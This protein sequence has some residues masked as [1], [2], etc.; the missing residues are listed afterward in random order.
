MSIHNKNLHPFG[1]FFLSI[2]VGLAA[3]LGAVAYRLLI[4]FFHNLL[5]LGRFSF[6]YDTSLHTPPSP[7]GLGVI[8]VPVVGAVGVAFLVK[9]FAPEAKGTGI[10]E[11]IDAVYYKQGKI[12]PVIAI[13]KSLAS[14]LSLGSGASVGR[15]G[16]ITQIGSSFGSMVGQIIRMP[17]WQRVSLVAAGA[18]GGIAATFNTPVGGMLFAIEIILYELS[19]RT[20]VPLAISAS[21]ATLV[22]RLILGNRPSF[23]NL[24]SEF[25]LQDVTHPVLLL[26][27]AGLGVLTGLASVL[28]IKSIYGFEDLFDHRM[29][30]NYYA[31]HMVGMFLVGVMMYALMIGFGHYYIEDVGY[32]TIQNLLSGSRLPVLLLFLLFGAK[33]FATSLSLGS[34]ASGGIFSPSLYLGATLG[35]LYGI[36]LGQLI[37]GLGIN[38]VPFA[39]VGMASLVGGVTGAPVAAIV[40]LFEMTLSYRFIL[41]LVI[42]VAVS[43][44][45]RKLLSQESIYTLM[46]VRRGHLVPETRQ[47]NLEQLVRAGDVMQKPLGIL[48]ASS[49][50]HEC[51]PI[52]SG[53]PATL[54]WFLVEDDSGRIIGVVNRG[55]AFQAMA[56]S[57][58]NTRLVDI[59]DK[60]TVTVSEEMPLFDVITQMRSKN[61]SVALVTGETG[62]ISSESVKGL[63]TKEVIGDFVEKSIGLFLD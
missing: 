51:G 32:A 4:A 56:P 45:T 49:T 40:M 14:A 7:W 15:E 5:F 55:T 59:V 47:V 6:F 21:T 37:P 30:S 61:A 8:L 24:G 48:S 17:R 25:P 10:P 11:V 62:E 12:R 13:I 60:R 22:S 2:L 34:G 54:P 28:L 3:G 63:I 53:Q 26:S 50:L 1:L 38:P 23:V 16:P 39:L 44:G 9:N 42:A 29:S 31:R 20:F 41:A 33:L 27:Y 46:L 36:T 52:S 58:K 43:Y 57:A 19:V 18:G 35:G